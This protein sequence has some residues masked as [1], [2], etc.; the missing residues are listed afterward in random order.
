MVESGAG[1]G[2]GKAVGVGIAVWVGVE[3]G[4][5]TC[6]VSASEPPEHETVNSNVTVRKVI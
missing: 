6:G 1:V 3:V 2:S 5:A 4:G